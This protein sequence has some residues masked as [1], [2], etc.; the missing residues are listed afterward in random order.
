M[1]SAAQAIFE[2]WSPP[3]FLTLSMLL[4]AAVYARGW[5][6]IRKTRRSQFPSWRLCCF[7][8]GI[9]ILWI[10]IASPLDGFADALLSAHMVEHL[11]L[12]S[13]VPPLV[14]LGQPVV[15]LLRGL[16]RSF[17]RSILG[18]FIRLRSLRRLTH[19]LTT[20]LVAWI[21]MNLTFLVWHIPAAYDFALGNE[22]VHDF[23]HLCFLGTAILF[24]WPLLRPWPWRSASLGWFT[25]PYLVFADIVNTILSAFLAFCERPV[26]SYYL[27]EPNAFGIAPLADQR[28]GAA[29]MWV[30]GSIV[31][32]V[33]AVIITF[34]LLGQRT[35]P[36]NTH[37]VRQPS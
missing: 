26:Y 13:F 21:A 9:G 17:T 2:E 4:V 36:Q 33:P 23:E 30:I 1:E 16:P 6:L 19:W 15:P 5:F 20:P 14:L 28:A 27:R 7:L 3:L 11:L 24:W 29:A 12:M 22:R 31:F 37:T 25:L 35:G 18:P 32:L 8:L 10:S 34:L